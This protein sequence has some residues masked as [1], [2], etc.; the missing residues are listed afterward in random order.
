MGAVI[1][2][3]T[4]PYYGVSQRDGS[5]RL[6]HVPAGRYRLK[7]WAEGASDEVLEELAR[8]IVI[9]SDVN[10]GDIRIRVTPSVNLTHANKFGH[11]YDAV[12]PSYGD[13]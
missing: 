6:E 11:S 3:L 8:D 5:V 9:T 2:A 4:A 1:I 12:I 10:L 13:H 7:L